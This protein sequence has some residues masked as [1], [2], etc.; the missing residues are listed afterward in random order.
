MPVKARFIGMLAG[1]LLLS[2]VAFAGWRMLEPDAAPQVTY[3]LIDG[4][5]IAQQQLRGKVVLVNFW[6]TSC[7]TCVREMPALAETHRRFSARGF[8]TVAVAMAYDRPDHVLHFARTRALPFAVALDLQGETAAAFG[9][10]AV[11][12]TSFLIDRDGRIIEQWVGAPDFDALHALIE[13]RLPG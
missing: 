6:A 8:E 13:R 2:L 11:T 7:V 4:R 5:R 9:D 12:P 1:V 3:K 10:V